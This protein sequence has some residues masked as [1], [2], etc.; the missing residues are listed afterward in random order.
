MI[1]DGYLHE[2]PDIDPDETEEWVA[3]LDAVVDAR[4]KN[5]ARFLMRK[6]LERAR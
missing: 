4:G 3:S 6:L 2:L 5:R 1:I